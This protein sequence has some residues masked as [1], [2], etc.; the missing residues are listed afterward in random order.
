MRWHLLGM[1]LVILVIP[2]AAAQERK[3]L[4]G[5][6]W[7][8]SFPVAIRRA[9]SGETP[10]LF[11]FR[12][13]F[14]HDYAYK[15]ARKGSL[16]I[17]NLPATEGPSSSDRRRIRTEERRLRTSRDYERREDYALRRLARLWRWRTLEGELFRDPEVMRTCQVFERARIDLGT[18]ASE[19]AVALALELKVLSQKD[20]DRRVD[21]L[22]YPPEIRKLRLQRGLWEYVAPG[23]SKYYTHLPPLSDD[24][25]KPTRA[26]TGET[27]KQIVLDARKLLAE[28]RT[29]IVVTS[30]QGEIL[31]SSKSTLTKPQLLQAVAHTLGP[32]KHWH[33]AK[34]LLSKNDE[35]AALPHLASIVEEKPK[36]KRLV[37]LARR[38]LAPIEKNALVLLE[39][40]NQE[41][42]AGRKA[43]AL[44]QFKQ[45]KEQNYDKLS[46][47]IANQIE[48]G[49]A[50][51][52][53]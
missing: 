40:A 3:P 25:F 45:L 37:E 19:R 38:V 11:F 43:E 24:K 53:K 4:R 17:T 6:D 14:P 22:V 41:L 2:L 23:G 47:Q 31:F 16:A 7:S 34:K 26:V 13:D 42:K 10:L 29:A 9:R 12:D 48:A 28:E 52:G 20:I 8:D 15:M 36:V 5:L 21:A 35:A 30:D 46:A 18:S 33:E 1:L 50:A 27:V 51:A 32:Y 44:E 39:T 49:L